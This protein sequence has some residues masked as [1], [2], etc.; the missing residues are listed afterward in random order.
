M[1]KEEIG[2]DG[3]Y[4]RV[5]TFLFSIVSAEFSEL[6]YRPTDDMKSF[7]AERSEK[8]KNCRCCAFVSVS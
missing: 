5:V 2:G 7:D 1:E 8:N 6:L 3:C 4:R